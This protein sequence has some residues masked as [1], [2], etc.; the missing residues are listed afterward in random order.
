VAKLNLDA[1][2]TRAEAALLLGVSVTTV[3]KWQAR[4]WIGPDGKRRRLTSRMRNRRDLEYRLGD[5]LE[6]EKHTYRSGQSRRRP[7]ARP[8]LAA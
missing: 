7:A 2:L 8:G 1:Y 3:A 6:A 5:L 4:G